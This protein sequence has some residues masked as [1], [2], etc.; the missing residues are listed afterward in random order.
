MSN[1][2]AIATVTATLREW[3]RPALEVDVTGA[4][5]SLNRPDQIAAFEN[6]GVNVFLYQVT[7][8]A[9]WR[10]QDL[11]TRR[12]SNGEVLQ[13]PQAA[14]DLHYL[15]TCFGDE[16]LLEPSGFWAVWSAPCTRVRR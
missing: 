14:L 10:N 1:D 3:I 15:L 5:V 16:T 4:Q 9:A 13:R 8:N 2:L 12:G 7:P 11:P 6:P